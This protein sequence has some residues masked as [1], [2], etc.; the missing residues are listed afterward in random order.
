MLL[1]GIGETAMAVDGRRRAAQ[2]HDFEHAPATIQ[3]AGDVFT[4]GM[5]HGIVVGT[6]EGGKVRAVGLSVEEDDLD[7]FLIGAVDGWRD[8]RHLVG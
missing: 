7:A 8:G 1:H 5:S 4:H 2:A 6:H 3:F